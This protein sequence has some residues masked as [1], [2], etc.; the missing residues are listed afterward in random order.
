MNTAE[1][2]GDSPLE[3][4]MR[5]SLVGLVFLLSVT[6]TVRSVAES[7]DQ[8]PP[9]RSRS[10][11]DTFQ[12][13]CTIERPNF[14]RI[15]AKAT[16]LR[17]RAEP[18]GTLSSPG[19]TVFR[20]KS[21]IGNL[22]TGPFVLLLDET[23]GPKGK[24]TSCAIVGEVPD[25][26]AFRADAVEM[27]KLPPVPSPEMGREGSRS[28]IWNGALGQG[29]TLILRDFKPVEKPGVMLKVIAVEEPR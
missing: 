10:L 12:V 25:L 8:T 20:N 11:I 5:L 9:D 27:L 15:D 1:L 24:A 7:N 2:A 3:D 19:D 14:E 4:A 28:F 29:T 17:M 18:G 16:A 21:W 13:M 6:G 22:T 23:S 26:D